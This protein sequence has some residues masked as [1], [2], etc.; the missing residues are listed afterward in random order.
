MTKYIQTNQA[1]YITGIV[2]EPILI[3]LFGGKKSLQVSDEE[4]TVIEE[5]L[6]IKHSTG[7]GLR[8]EDLE[9]LK[10]ENENR[11]KDERK[12][13]V[14]IVEF[15]KEPAVDNHYCMLN[16]ESRGMEDHATISSLGKSVASNYGA[17]FRKRITYEP[18]EGIDRS[19]TERGLCPRRYHKLSD[20]EKDNFEKEVLASLG[21]DKN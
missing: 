4:A 15:L 12:E 18:S 14:G 7:E 11:K 17:D 21:Q 10:A 16:L 3:G 9:G 20:L 19:G 13:F 8:I 6:R 5:T 2:K 1:G